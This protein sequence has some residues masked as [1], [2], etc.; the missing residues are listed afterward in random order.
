M[1]REYFITFRCH[2]TWLHGDAQGSV[3]RDH[4]VWG[5]PLLPPDPA[6]R[7]RENRDL[8]QPPVA[9]DAQ[10][11]FIVDRT[12]REVCAHRGWTVHALNVRSTH[13]HLVVRADAEPERVMND[14][15][16][17]ATRR[18]REAGVLASDLQ[19]WSYHGSTK[20]L[21]TSD[22][23]QA[24]VRYTNQEQG[25]PLEMTCPPG[26]C[27]NTIRKLPPQ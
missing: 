14:C 24:A 25:D 8:K 1:A 12:L 13:V 10:Q 16:A 22:G 4:N 3:D 6:R 5:T 27:A 2:G 18:M 21:I 7:S 23:F 9:L 17:Y 15:K 26:W 20:H 19:P 11:R